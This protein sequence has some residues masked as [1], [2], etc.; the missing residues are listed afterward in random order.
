MP[1]KYARREDAILH[2]L[3]LEGAQKLEDKTQHEIGGLSS[4]LVPNDVDHKMGISSELRGNS[5]F[6]HELTHYGAS[7]EDTSFEKQISRKRK[8]NSPDDLEDIKKFGGVEELGVRLAFKKD[9]QVEVKSLDH[10][11]YTDSGPAT[12]SDDIDVMFITNVETGTNMKF[13][14]NK[15]LE[16]TKI[17]S[18]FSKTML[19]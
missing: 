7:S 12:S 17:E 3:K 6:G 16:I 1:T 4:H 13:K 8:M 15:K 19:M 10:Q 2:A 5:N 9:S 11:H 18:I 14:R